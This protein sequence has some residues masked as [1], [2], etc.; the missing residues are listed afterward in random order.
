MLCTLN[1]I[2]LF[3]L[4]ALRSTLYQ[5]NSGTSLAGNRKSLKI[6][7]FQFP[8]SSTRSRYENSNTLIGNGKWEI[9]NFVIGNRKSSLMGNRKS[10]ILETLKL[11]NFGTLEHWNIVTLELWN[12]GTLEYCNAGTFTLPTSAFHSSGLIF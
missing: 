8:I 1:P 6:S 10:E 11:W 3:T 4:Y 12:S 7:Y 9:G 5:R 2:P